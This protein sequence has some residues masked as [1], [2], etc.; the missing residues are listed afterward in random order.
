M[1]AGKKA[2]DREKEFIK[3]NKDTMCFCQIARELGE[4]FPMDNCGRR[5]RQFVRKWARELGDEEQI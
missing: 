1:V 3:A 2:S 5:E 4:L